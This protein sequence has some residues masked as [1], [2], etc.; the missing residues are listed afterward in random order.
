VKVAVEWLRSF[1]DYCSLD[2]AELAEKLTMAGLEVEE[3]HGSGADTVFVT[4]VTPNR[5]DWLSIFGVA[6]EL[7]AASSLPLNP[8]TV[9]TT[10]PISAKIEDLSVHVADSELCPR[11]SAAILHNVQQVPSPTFI[12]Q[13]LLLSGMRPLNAIVDITNYVML[14]LGQPLHAFDL[15]KLTGHQIV[16]RRAVDGE[17]ITTLDGAEY[18]LT[19]DIL[20]IADATKPI[21]LAGLM[22]GSETEVTSETTSI[23]LESAH[24]NAGIV[25]RGAKKLG[26]TT[27]ASYRF[28]RY[29]DPSLVPVAIARAV[30]LLTEFAGA[31]A[32]HA[33]IDSAPQFGGQR[34]VHLRVA[35]TNSLLGLNLT[36]DQIA[37][38]LRRL[39]MAVQ[40]NETDMDVLVPSYRPDLE[41]EVD[42][43]EE[44]G[45]MVGYW[46]LPEA[47]PQQPV[48]GGSDFVEGAFDSKLRSLLVGEGLTEAYNHT[49]GSTSFFDAPTD[50]LSRV[51]VRSS[52]SSELSGLRL[53]LLPHLL[54]S[55]ALNLRHGAHTVRL[56]EVG[57]VFNKSPEGG[58]SEPRHVAA[59]LCGGVADYATIKGVAENLL[60]ALDITSF[61]FVPSQ[62]WAMHPGRTSDVKV[63]GVT[64]GFVAE[65]DPFEVSEHLQLP[66]SIG[67]VATF[68][69]SAQLLRVASEDHAV[70]RRYVALPKFPIVTRDLA[71]VYGLDIPYGAIKKIVELSAG[72]LLEEVQLLSVYVGDKVSTGKKSVAVRMTLRSLTRTLTEADAETAMAA[73]RDAL[74][75]DLQAEQR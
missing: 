3:Q 53:T 4:K 52:L 12:Q 67:R 23:V 54:D 26:F 72:S 15:N 11:Y 49:L 75:T 62:R 57:K 5:G 17:K 34:D 29:V 45:R 39:G 6:R 25:R 55:V 44:V 43:I 13:R 41:R 36:A 20:V 73:A 9:L 50:A 7:S 48:A 51:A 42:V 70:V 31:I 68:E 30:G 24:F 38:S 74:I 33:V 65:V 27:E 63:A 18:D 22:G 16:V 66:P 8:S 64:V 28:E 32:E 59:V 14:E 46:N 58:F 21:G 2:D 71:L 37:Q 69:F 1:G 60:A 10:H 19:R 61:D 47:L 35:R 40:C 56:F